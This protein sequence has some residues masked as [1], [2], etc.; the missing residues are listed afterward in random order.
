MKHEVGTTPAEATCKA[1]RMYV[2][3]VTGLGHTGLATCHTT[4]AVL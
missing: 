3:P 4:A 1:L 2:A